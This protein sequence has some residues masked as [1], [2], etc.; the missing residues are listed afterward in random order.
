MKLVQAASPHH[1]T[2]S[3]DSMTALHVLF[4]IQEVEGKADAALVKEA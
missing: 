2:K 1:Y 3:P 4:F